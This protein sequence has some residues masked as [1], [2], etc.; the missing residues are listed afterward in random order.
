[1]ERSTTQKDEGR[2]DGEEGG[3]GGGERRGEREER[4]IWAGRR[5]FQ[6]TC[7]VRDRNM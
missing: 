7:L 2:G 5:F 6:F 4:R 3:R 1:M